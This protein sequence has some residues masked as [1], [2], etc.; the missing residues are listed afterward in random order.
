MTPND[1]D[2]DNQYAAA[3]ADRVLDH[4]RLQLSALIDG[5]LPLDEARFL[6]R[7]LDHDTELRECWE[8]WQLCGDVLRGRIG[9][10]ARNGLGE[11]V[12]E[13]IAADPVLVREPVARQRWLRLGGGAAL[14]ASVAIIALFLTRQSPDVR[15]PSA[16]L[17]AQVASTPVPTP[18]Q[19]PASPDTAVQTPQA[20]GQ[21]A[22]IASAL[23]VADVPRRLA[24]RRSRGQSQRAALRSPSRTAIETPVAVATAAPFSAP[25]TAVDPFS[26]QHVRLPNRPW[27]RALLPAAPAN[28]AFTVDYGSRM[29]MSARPLSPFA[30]RPLPRS[31]PEPDA[32]DSNAPAP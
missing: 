10:Y 15:V 20:P 13:A 26:G 5:E 23:A 27:P 17:P 6:L 1:H 8:R 29:D 9:V 2:T 14:A 4:T 21:A 16:G 11:R 18:G 24:T 25:A 32:P 31:L 22:E 3:S 30:P 28:G 19:R 12:A 7:R